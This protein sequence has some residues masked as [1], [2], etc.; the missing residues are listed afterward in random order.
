MEIMLVAVIAQLIFLECILSLDNAAVM[1]AMVA[2]LPNNKPVPWPR[3]LAGFGASTNRFW[4]AQ[5]DAALRIG[6]F[7]AYAGRVLMLF[8]AS[9]IMRYEWVQIAGALYLMYLCVAHFAEFHAEQ[10]E[11]GRAIRAG[12]GFWMVVLSLNLADMAFSL[13]NVVAALA[14]SDKLWVIV[15][16]VSIGI[17]VVR[18]A[19]SIFTRL[20][21]WE[22][23]LEHTAYLLVFAIGLE[24]LLDISL[25]IHTEDGFRFAISAGLIT[26]T[27]LIVR[28]RGLRP[29]LEL[30]RPLLQVAV[31]GNAAVLLL[32][33][34]I[35]APVRIITRR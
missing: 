30:A 25:G 14:L 35:T 32:V 12:A 16:G 23:A 13:D 26:G 2:H 28:T 9:L 24:L 4:G 22:P 20:I 21:G 33:G 18:F 3:F 5:Q 29:L 31:L 1:G 27:V 19:A 15:L 11:E 7:G 6:L 10:G 34:L 17:V 8:A